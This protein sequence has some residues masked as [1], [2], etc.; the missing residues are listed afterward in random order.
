MQN[1]DS[2]PDDQQLTAAEGTLMGRVR[3]ALEITEGVE[4][5]RRYFV[6]NAFDGALT[7]LGLLLA[8]LASMAVLAPRT[9]LST[10]LLAAM[11]TSTAMAISGFSGAYLAETAERNREVDEMQKAK[12]SQQSM[13]SYEDAVQTTSLVIAAVDGIAPLLAASAIMF[14]LVLA[15]VGL[16]DS[17]VGFDL[18]V[19][20]CMVVLA[21]LGVFLGRISGKDVW[22]FGVVTLLAGICTALV[23][24]VFLLAT[25]AVG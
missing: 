2:Q 22:V 14:P 9:A 3:R 4:I 17:S 15:S 10:T 7:M 19:A 18:A 1:D 21:L 11:G 13:S 20:I 16:L 23:M 8:G 25:S 12:Q 24:F 6:I 5:A